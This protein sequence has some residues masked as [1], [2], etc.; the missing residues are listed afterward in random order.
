MFG[1]SDRGPR[2]PSNF[3]VGRA[4]QRFATHPWSLVGQALY[5]SGSPVVGATVDLY[6]F[7]AKTFVATTTTDAN[8]VY[9]FTPPTNGA[10][11]A[12]GF[13]AGSP[14]YFFRTDILVPS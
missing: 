14:N 6:D 12:S 7:Y 3:G 9:A 11:F 4:A 5:P 8:G 13:L 10:Y 2:H 1:P